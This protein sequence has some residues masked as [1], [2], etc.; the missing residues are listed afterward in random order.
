MMSLM[1]YVETKAERDALEEHD[2]QQW[3]AK[4]DA[5]EFCRMKALLIETHDVLHKVLSM[6]SDHDAAHAEI[7]ALMQRIREVTQ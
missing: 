1:G 7:S 4:E 3:R 6:T 5:D 2:Y